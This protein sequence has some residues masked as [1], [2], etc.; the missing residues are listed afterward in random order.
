MKTRKAAGA[1]DPDPASI[2]ITTI[3]IAGSLASVVS[4][5]PVAKWYQE[6]T[7]RRAAARDTLTALDGALGEVR[8]YLR[9]LEIQYLASR[10]VAVREMRGLAFGKEQV[11]FEP[12]EQTQWFGT[13]QK[14]MRAGM[15]VHRS[16]AKVLRIY[17]GAKSRLPDPVAKQLEDGINGLNELLAGLH[18][19]EPEQAFGALGSTLDSIGAGI[20]S[21]REALK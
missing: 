11:F 18:G 2:I 14:L 6:R 1:L 21:L 3:G 20:R 15:R 8:G 5:P 17:A 4:I 19:M 10:R 16:L 9:S 12:P 7:D 13:V